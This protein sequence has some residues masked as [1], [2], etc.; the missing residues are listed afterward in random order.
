MLEE[1]LATAFALKSM[2]NLNKSKYKKLENFVQHQPLQY[3]YGLILLKKYKDDIENIMLH[4]KL[5]KDGND[6]KY[7]Y[8]NLNDDLINKLYVLTEDECFLP[9]AAKEIFIF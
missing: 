6:F 8:D 1:G 3:R 7:D 4:W 2:K 9:D 5:Y